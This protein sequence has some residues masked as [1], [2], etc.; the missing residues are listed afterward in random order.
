MNAQVSG[1]VSLTITGILKDLRADATQ[2][3]DAR[4]RYILSGKLD[5]LHQAVERLSAS[6][7]HTQRLRTL[8]SDGQR[9]IAQID[10]MALLLSNEAQSLRALIETHQARG[11]PAAIRAIREAAPAEQFAQIDRLLASLTA[12]EADGMRQRS[13]ASKHRAALHIVT[14][15]VANGFNV[16]LLAL[17]MYL[18]YREVRERRASELLLRFNATHDSLTNLMNRHA[19]AERVNLALARAGANSSKVGL[20]FLDLDRFKHINDTLGHEIGDLVLQ[21]VAARLLRCV[22]KS[23]FVARQGGDEFVALIE[24][25]A[26]QAVLARIA[27]T[28][29]TEVARPILIRDREFRV[30]ASIGISSFPDHGGDLQVLLKNA[31]IAMYRA[32]DK[33][34][35]TYQFYSIREDRHSLRR[36]D[37]EAALRRAIESED[38]LMYYQPRV[39]AS[40]H[41]IVAVEGLLRWPQSDSRLVAPGQVIPLVEELGLTRQLGIW[42]LRTACAQHA[43]WTREGMPAMRVAINVSPRQLIDTEFVSDVRAALDE[44]GLAARWLELEITEGVM[45]REPQK[46]QA[47]LEELKSM[48]AYISVDDFG[49]GYSSMAYLKQLPLDCLKIDR[50]FIRGLPKDESDVAIT[51]AIVNMAHSLGLRV[52]AEGVE[53]KQQVEFLREHNCDEFQGYY[54]GKPMPPQHIVDLV[55]APRKAGSQGRLLQLPRQARL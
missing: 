23:D 28:M 45:M 50:A 24:D 3:E 39:C 32:K 31:D 52:V 53:T 12:A 16:G 15:W 51:R 10:R 40:T 27:E 37:M 8:G 48:G 25:I 21:E 33:G 34:K 46:A 9:E 14:S 2:I 41:E 20:L 13:E 43:R 55:L 47:I 6:L 22:R 5:H 26:D 30:T 18:A 35:N 1:D 11:R 7:E 17:I 38:L 49:I 29:L 19:L 54:F 4:R 42:A 44:R 36:L